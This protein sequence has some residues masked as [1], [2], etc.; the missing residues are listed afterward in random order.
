[1]LFARCH[2]AISIN[3]SRYFFLSSWIYNFK[4]EGK[5]NIYFKSLINVVNLVTG[6]LCYANIAITS[7]GFLPSVICSVRGNQGA[8]WQSRQLE[9]CWGAEWTVVAFKPLLGILPGPTEA[10]VYAEVH[11]STCSLLMSFK[12]CLARP[13]PT[14][15]FWFFFFTAAAN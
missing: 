2:I 10:R 11:S 9:V 14:V 3:K 6:A 15:M 12:G 1:M 8:L 4:K 7:C 5:T 13:V